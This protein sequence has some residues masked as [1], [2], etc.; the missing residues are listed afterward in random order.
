MGK[1]FLSQMSPDEAW[2]EAVAWSGFK[3]SWLLG[4]CWPSFSLGFLWLPFSSCFGAKCIQMKCHVLKTWKSLQEIMR[5]TVTKHW[6]R[7]CRQRTYCE[8]DWS[9]INTHACNLTWG[10]GVL[11]SILTSITRNCIYEMCAFSSR[12]CD[13]KGD[14]IRESS[15]FHGFLPRQKASFFLT[16]RNRQ[17]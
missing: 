6:P 9:M 2:T 10:R 14:T 8:A 17:S 7:V 3:L 13:G 16:A 15:S 5:D 1:S 4:E 12:K 11:I